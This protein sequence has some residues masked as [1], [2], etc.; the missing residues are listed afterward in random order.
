[1][2]VC[3][4]SRRGNRFIPYPRHYSEAFA[5]SIILCPLRHQKPLRAALS[6]R[7]AG[8]RVGF[9]AF[10]TSNKGWEGSA[11]SPV[12]TCQRIR[13]KQADNRSHAI[14]A[15]ARYCKL[16]LALS[17][18]TTFIS[19]SLTLTIQPSLAPHPGATPEITPDPSRDMAYPVRWL[20]C[21]SARHPT[22]TSGALLL[23]YWGLNPRIN[24]SLAGAD[25]LLVQP[26]LH[27]QI[28]FPR[29]C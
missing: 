26:S 8:R 5:F 3:T 27:S 25:Q 10:R 7:L 15:R 16:P 20:H 23:D 28:E 24:S 29:S 13:T 17:S 14:L 19:G 21:Q 12:I 22:V 18:L 4:L 1:M 6:A 11:I 2:E 9:T